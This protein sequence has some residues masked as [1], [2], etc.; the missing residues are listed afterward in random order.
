MPRRSVSPAYKEALAIARRDRLEQRARLI[1]AGVV[2]PKTQRK[3][4]YNQ[5][6]VTRNGETFDSL[7]EAEQ[8]NKFDLLKASGKILDW[9]RPKAIILLDAPNSRGRISY[10]PDFLV[11]MLDNSLVY[12]DYKGSRITET[13]SWKIKVK[14]WNRFIHEELRVIYPTGEQKVV[15]IAH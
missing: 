13:A 4:K 10:K 8:A 3:N 14:L 5:V 15:S 2:V 7:G 1:G 11:K 9:E 12:F 6:R